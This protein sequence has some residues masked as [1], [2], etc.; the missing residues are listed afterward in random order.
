[1]ARATAGIVKWAPERLAA[2]KGGVEVH[3]GVATELRAGD[4]VHWTRS[5][6]G[7]GLANGATVVVER[8]ERD[9]VRFQLEDGASAR[10][11]NGD[12]QLRHI[13]RA[14]A[15][16][17]RAFRGRT[18]DRIIAAMPADHPNLTTQQAVYVAISRA[19]DRA[20][21]VTD[22]AWKLADQLERATGERAA[23]LDGM[24]LQAAHE[25]ASGV[26]SRAER[27]PGHARHAPEATDRGREA[28]SEDGRGSGI[29]QRHGAK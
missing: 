18:V 10:L 23:A 17:V 4:R 24:A 26:G 11:A 28:P 12:P 15:A 3:R 8:I 20:D 13:D 5:D 1:M 9:G 2:A 19:R 29:R 27:E 14:W 22:D 6:L 16:T 7:A 21:L 25:T